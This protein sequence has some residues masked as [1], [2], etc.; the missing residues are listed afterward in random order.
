MLLREKK[1]RE[2]MGREIVKGDK[3]GE[4]GERKAKLGPERRKLLVH[5]S[6]SLFT[7]AWA[8]GVSSSIHSP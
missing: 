6:P 3:E 7:F 2:G 5:Q 4:A 1:R 8:L